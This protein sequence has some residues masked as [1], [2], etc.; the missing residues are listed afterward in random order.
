M[1]H[2]TFSEDITGSGQWIGIIIRHHVQSQ[3]VTVKAEGGPQQI[4]VVDNSRNPC[5]SFI[6]TNSLEVNLIQVT[7]TV[8]VPNG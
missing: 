3:G 4:H 6:S 8:L 5:I 2:K 7:G 1:E